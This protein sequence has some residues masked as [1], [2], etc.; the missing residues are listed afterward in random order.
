MFIAI[1][2]HEKAEGCWALSSDESP[3]RLEVV[4]DTHHQYGGD[5]PLVEWTDGP[6][7]VIPV[8]AVLLQ[9]DRSLGWTFDWPEEGGRLLEGSIRIVTS[10]ASGPGRRYDLILDVGC[11][12][13]RESLLALPEDDSNDSAELSV[14]RVVGPFA[15]AVSLTTVHW[16]PPALPRVDV[17]PARDRIS[18]WSRLGGDP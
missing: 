8:R 3:G 18:A 11:R 13:L 14:L 7:G 5:P 15:S 10:G 12:T 2:D 1:G 6:V 9:D 17:L 4:F 16:T